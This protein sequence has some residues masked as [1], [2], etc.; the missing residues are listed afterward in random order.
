VL[1][2]GLEDE[3]LFYCSVVSAKSCLGGCM[4]VKVVSCGGESGVNC[5]HEDFR[6]GWGDGNATVIF[7]VS[8]VAFAFIQW[9]HLGC[10][11]R[12]RWFLVYCTGIEKCGQAFYSFLP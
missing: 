12:G 2:D 6:E 4:Q 5:G 9:Y 3:R 8:S 11:P 1:D 10:S 7:W